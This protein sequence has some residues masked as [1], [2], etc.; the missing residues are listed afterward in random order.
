MREPA[1]GDDVCLAWLGLPGRSQPELLTGLLATPP[2]A[3]G[4]PAYDSWKGSGLCYNITSV[5]THPKKALS[6]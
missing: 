1:V 2:V 6:C 4:W 3:V 5:I